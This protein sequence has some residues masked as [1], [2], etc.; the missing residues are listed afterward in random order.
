MNNDINPCKSCGQKAVLL[1]V[2]PITVPPFQHKKGPL[3]EM[4]Y[5]HFKQQKNEWAMTHPLLLA[6]TV[7]FEDFGY[8]NR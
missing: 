4:C 3:L 1:W 6:E 2:L 5:K 7:G 8:I